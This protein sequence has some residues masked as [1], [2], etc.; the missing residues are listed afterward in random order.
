M[1]VILTLRQ[2]ALMVFL[3]SELL[4]CLFLFDSVG[5]VASQCCDT[6]VCPKLPVLV[7]FILRD[8]AFV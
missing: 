3:L 6:A 7:L 4:I 1:F 8:C 5:D 2:E